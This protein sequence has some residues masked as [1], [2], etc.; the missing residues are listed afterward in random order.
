[1]RQVKGYGWRPDLPDH[2]DLKL[3]PP[4]FS[5]AALPQSVDLRSGCP[6]VYDQGNLGS[7]TANAIGAAIQYL[8]LRDVS[9]PDFMPSRL[10][11]YYNERVEEGDVDQDN[12]AQIRDGIKTVA[13]LGTT[14]E[15]DWPYDVARFAVKPSDQAFMNALTFNAFTQKSVKYERVT[16]DLTHLKACLASGFPFVFGFSV[17]EGFESEEVAKT[18]DLYLPKPQEKPVGGHAVMAVGYD[19]N[20]EQFLVRNS[21]G[22]DWG[23]RGYFWMPYSYMTNPGLADDFWK[24]SLVA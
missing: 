24:I 23:N 14:S 19:D 22:A 21:W 4:T 2:R 15:E 20:I 11:I 6:P 18:G 10:F 8:L 5:P 13:K 16:Q 3:A 12:G 1:M 9:L 7:C 17:F